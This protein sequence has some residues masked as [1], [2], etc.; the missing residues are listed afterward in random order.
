MKKYIGLILCILVV[1]M[2]IGIVAG[3]IIHGEQYTVT[4][5]ELSELDDGIYGIYAVVS[6]T[7]PAHNYEIIT[8]CYNGQI[9]TFKGYVN[10]HYSEKIHKLIYKNKNAINSD[11]M[12]VY[13][14]RG[15]IEISSNV[16]LGR[17]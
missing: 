2:V 4:E 7:I 17:R 8:L 16:G 3:L 12:D 14:P 10:I 5:Y 6:S 15:S 13:V 11:T 1:I 9:H